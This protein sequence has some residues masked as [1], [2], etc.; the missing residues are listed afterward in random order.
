MAELFGRAEEDKKTSWKQIRVTFRGPSSY[1]RTYWLGCFSFQLAHPT[2][3][4]HQGVDI[5]Q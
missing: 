2:A 3:K 1:G 4:G 5:L